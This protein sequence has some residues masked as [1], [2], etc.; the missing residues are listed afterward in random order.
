LLLKKY[1]EEAEKEKAI[2]NMKLTN[3]TNLV[4]SIL[5]KIVDIEDIEH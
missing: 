3:Y 5:K 4:K 1:I 2:N